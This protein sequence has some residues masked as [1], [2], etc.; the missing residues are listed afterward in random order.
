MRISERQRAPTGR[1]NRARRNDLNDTVTALHLH[2]VLGRAYYSHATVV[3][4]ERPPYYLLVLDS[5]GGHRTRGVRKEIRT[6]CT[7]S[8][9]RS[10]A[11][12]RVAMAP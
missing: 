12:R 1:A 2:P 6:S 5:R 3:R 10:M 8:L 7:P 9:Q 4:Q 11:A